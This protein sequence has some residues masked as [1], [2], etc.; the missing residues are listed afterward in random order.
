[1]FEFTESIRIEAQSNAV[2]DHLA[3]VERWWLPSNPD[4]IGLEVRSS[5]NGIGI[6]TEV[7][8]EERIAGIKGKAV[9]TI[10]SLIHGEKIT[11]EGI[12][13][14]RYLGFPFHI[15]EGVSW[16]VESH[17]QS[18]TLSARVWAEFP[19]S[20]FG[21]IFEWYAKSFLNI[22]ARDREHARREL[23]YLKSAIEHAG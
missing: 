6:G 14:Y 7:V 20:T 23:V 19:S 12:A 15:R 5:N 18:S 22:V 16:Q 4:H 1:M 10:T 8:F 13:E 17:T 11:W 3:D 9:G 2:W 21:R